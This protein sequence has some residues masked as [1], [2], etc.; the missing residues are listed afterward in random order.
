MI[1]QIRCNFEVDA[2]FDK[3]SVH[4]FVWAKHAYF[5]NNVKYL[6]TIVNRIFVPKSVQQVSLLLCGLSV[7]HKNM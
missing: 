5:N 3:P 6:Q 2:L 4:Q 1:Q 7:P